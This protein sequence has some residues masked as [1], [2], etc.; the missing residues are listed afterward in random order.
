MKTRTL[1]LA[2]ALVMFALPT[3]A[4]DFDLI[5]QPGYVNLDEIEIPDNAVDVTE[6][7]IGPELFQMIQNFSGEDVPEMPKMDGFMNIQVKTFDVDEL[8]AQELRPKMEKL[9]AK[10]RRENWVPIVRVRSGEE[11]T[12]VSM[13]YSKDKKK[14]LGL[15][16]MSL[17]P[18]ENASFVNIVGNVDMNMLRN[19]DLGIHGSALDSLKKVTEDEDDEE[20]D[21]E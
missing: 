8:M 7:S 6:V 5:S 19:M 17:N 10:L 13:K 18:S 16:I 20:E 21:D 14:S 11:F 15:F 9:E 1:Y 3:F 2:S 4:Q 12:N